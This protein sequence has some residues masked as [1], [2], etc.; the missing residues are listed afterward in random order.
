MISIG[1]TENKNCPEIAASSHD[2][3]FKT[4]TTKKSAST[5]EKIFHPSS[6]KAGQLARKAI[7]KTKISNIVNE[8]HKKHN[9]S[10]TSKVPI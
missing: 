1:K 6:R 4:M 5:K 7:R 8:R 10:G 3:F 2:F 9:A